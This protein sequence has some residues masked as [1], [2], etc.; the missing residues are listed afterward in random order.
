MI[1]KERKEDRKNL[2]I[3]SNQHEKGER[4]RGTI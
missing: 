2:S 4:R 1:R 3:N